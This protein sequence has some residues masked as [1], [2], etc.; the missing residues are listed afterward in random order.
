[1]NRFMTLLKKEVRELLTLQMI[2]PMIMGMLVL[3]FIGNVVGEESKKSLA[4]QQI[5]LNDRDGTDLSRQAATLLET[6][7]YRVTRMADASMEEM[8]ARAEAEKITI[9]LTIPDGF[10]DGIKAFKQQSLESYTIMRSFGVFGSVSGQAADAAV[11]LISESV[12]RYLISTHIQGGTPD[13]LDN[14]VKSRQY[15][16]VNGQTAEVA[17]S[18]IFNQ[19]SMQTM[20]VPIVMFIV[21]IMASQSI[22]VA[23]ASE[24]ENKTL[25]TLLSTPVSR[26]A[27]VTSKMVAAGLVSLLMALFYMI[28]FNSY[29]QGMTG[30]VL[31]Q[32]GK[33][34][35]LSE[36]MASLNLTLD[37]RAMVMVGI[38]LFLGI[39]IALAV[40]LIIGAFAEDVK[41]AQGLIAPFIFVI[42]VPY[43]LSM[44]VNLETASPALRFLVYAIPFSHAFL[45]IQNIYLG[46]NLFLLAG[47][48]YQL[49]LFA[50]LAYFAT[51]IFTTDKILT[52]KWK[53]GKK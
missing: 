21:I 13:T 24:K 53:L 7:G 31:E 3:M 34:T 49:I 35:Q 2:I 15:T 51:R 10:E 45:A 1:M 23:V 25:E 11:N 18:A 12:R 17:A 4:S 9:L 44:F 37:T 27:I 29:I 20:F 14:P 48:A 8:T 46:K 50:A 52:M 43:I 30:G 40:A 28:G 19:I 33:N 41:K 36:I 47:I 16:V 42:M 26:M 38:L 5:I 39:L 22:V 6:Q 32:A